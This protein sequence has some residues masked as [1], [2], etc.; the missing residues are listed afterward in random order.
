MPSKGN[1]AFFE[2]GQFYKQ[3]GSKA[4]GTVANP[5]SMATGTTSH[6]YLIRDGISATIPQ[7]Q[8]AIATFL[9]GGVLLGQMVG[10]VESLGQFDVTLANFDGAL[11][12]LANRSNVDTTT[13]SGWTI[14]GPNHANPTLENL[15]SIFTSRF[16]SRDDGSDGEEYYFNLFIPNFKMEIDL[17]TLT[18][19]GGTNPSTTRAIIRPTMTTKFPN[20]VAFGANQ[21]WKQ[22][23]TDW[24][25]VIAEKPIGLTVFNAAEDSTSFTLGWLPVYED[26]TSGNTKNWITKNGTPTAPTSISAATGTVAIPAGANNDLW[27]ALFLTDFE[28]V[29]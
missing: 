17:A 14:V 20:G 2:Y 4:Y 16:Q 9:G 8:R 5:A 18:Q 26:V 13:V 15:G 7:V 12:A 22:N 23:R 24:F 1:V 28:A 3:Y 25:Y 29:A 27:H 19:Q 11:M 6:S 10:G 21:G